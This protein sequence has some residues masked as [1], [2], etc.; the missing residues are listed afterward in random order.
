MPPDPNT[1][2][3]PTAG[4]EALTGLVKDIQTKIEDGDKR[5]SASLDDLTN[6]QK[7]LEGWVAEV[8][9]TVAKARTTHQATG[10]L[11]AIKS[12]I[13]DRHRKALE[14]NVRF[15]LPVERAI[16]VTAME[17]WMKNSIL[18]S[19]P[20]VAN[21]IGSKLLDEMD[22]IE[23][24]FGF[25]PISK[26]LQED[27]ATE[28]GNII[29]T[30]V[31][32]EVLRVELDAAVVSAMCRQ[33]PMITKTHSF[34]SLS[35][36]LSVAIVAEEGTITPADP[37]FGTKALTAK[38]IATRCIA[39]IELVQDSA[40]GL[41]SFL[42]T[43]MSEQK[44]L[45]LDK[46]ILEGDGTGS[47][48]TGVSAAASVNE[49][50]AAG[51]AAGNGA[52]PNYAQLIAQKWKGRKRSTRRGCAFVAA[53]EVLMKYEQL[54]DSQNRPLF[55]VPIAGSETLL[56]QGGGVSAPDGFL[57]GFKAFSHDQILINRTVGTSTDCSN[58]YFGPWGIAVIV[59]RLLGMQFGVSEHTQWATG[60]LDLRM[61][62]RE[63][64]LVAIPE[65]MT[66]QT[67]LRTT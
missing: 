37:A 44:G 21:R 29:P 5:I 41:L 25:E 20:Q 51:A 47:N 55:V 48:F 50:F 3:P 1:A 45:F 67:G 7:K 53:P 61:L 66:K 39:S 23:R 8:E 27:Q 19:N 62:S 16:R 56:N 28:G 42:T 38:K 33:V 58:M 10:E 9:K 26:A 17:T 63:A 40:V 35:T 65:A 6:G 46:Q 43:L 32:A 57:Q 31:E 2:T 12:A 64:V 54:L 30:P 59:G 4:F 13:P 24:S 11:D 22:K 60:Q 18:M 14:L 36:N 49:V 34:P 15:G 52:A